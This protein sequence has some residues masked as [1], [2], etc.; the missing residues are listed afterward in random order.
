MLPEFH[1]QMVSLYADYGPDKLLQF[2]KS[3]DHYPIHDAMLICK[4]RQLYPEMIYLLSK[5]WL[6][7]ILMSL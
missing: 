5:C 7:F 2:L 3:S 6:F 4:K 1:G